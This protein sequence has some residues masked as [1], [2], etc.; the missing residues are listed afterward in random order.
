MKTPSLKSSFITASILA[1]MGYAGLAMAYGVGSAVLD[2]AGNNAS[3][4]DLASVNCPAGTDHLSA[5]VQDTSSGAPGLLVSLHLFKD[6]QMT[7]VTDTVSADGNWSPIAT[8]NGG[9]GTYYM[10]VR[11]TTAGARNFIV[12]WECQNVDNVGTG[13]DITVLQVQ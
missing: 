1:A 3:A 12:G 4:T 11:K 7:T 6:T 10:S 5:A 2:P 9:A 13:T 8:L